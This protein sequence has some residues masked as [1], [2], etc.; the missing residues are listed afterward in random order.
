MEKQQRNWQ[1]KRPNLRKKFYFNIIQRGKPQGSVGIDP[2]HP[3]ADAGRDGR[4]ERDHQEHPDGIGWSQ[5]PRS[6]VSGM[7]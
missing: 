1:G 7:I 2:G 4:F 3:R 6:G 5:D